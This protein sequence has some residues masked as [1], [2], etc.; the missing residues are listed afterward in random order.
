MGETSSPSVMVAQCHKNEQACVDYYWVL[1]TGAS[2]HI[3]CNVDQLI[4]YSHFLGSDGVLGNGE[5]ISIASIRTNKLFVSND[6]VLSLDNVLYT[7]N[8]TTNLISIN[9]FCTN[10]CVS[11]KFNMY[12]VYVKDLVSKEVKLM[13]CTK[14][15]AMPIM[16]SQVLVTLLGF[17]FT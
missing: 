13:V 1:D 5:K 12:G 6:C 17:M 11:I 2:H 9:K 15:W 16:V 8:A 7:P 10:N 14:W 4:Q 3:M